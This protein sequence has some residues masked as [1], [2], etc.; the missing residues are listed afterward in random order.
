ML[1]RLSSSTIIVLANSNNVKN[2]V[3]ANAN[4]PRNV[5]SMNAR[6]EIITLRPH[7]LK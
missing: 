7:V 2:V 6:T 3:D 5:Q 1:L 4:L